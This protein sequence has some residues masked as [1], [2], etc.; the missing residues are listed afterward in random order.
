MNYQTVLDYLKDIELMGVKPELETARTILG[1]LPRAEGFSSIRFIQVAGT[2]GKGSTSHFLAG[3]LRT[4]GYRVGLFTS[5]HLNDIRERVLINHRLVSEPAFAAGVTAVKETSEKLLAAG[6]IDRMPTYFEY[7]FLTA[8]YCF[9]VHPV[10]VII[11]EVGLGGR[12]DA[13]T[14]IRPDVSVITTIS[15]DHTAMLG[16]RLRDIAAEKAGIIKEAVPVICGC[17]PRTHAFQVIKTIAQQRNAPFHPVFNSSN[18]LEI[19]PDNSAYHCTY[20]TTGPHPT[21]PRTDTFDIRLNG[22]HQALNAAIAVKALRVLSAVTPITIPS[23]SIGPGI[24]GTTLPARI[25]IFDTTPPVIVDGGHNV[26]SVTA[27]T[28]FLSEKNKSGLTLIFGVLDD[29]NY[30]RMIRLLLPYTRSV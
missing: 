5:P 3:I 10:E 9:L 7:T 4:A 26:Q 21:G 28:R 6:S 12:W 1:H 24:E 25:E 20:T 30:P 29:K 16:T 13:T 19:N 18:K 8:I 27:L 11:L 23:E 2:N 14:A 15:H 22:S 17:P